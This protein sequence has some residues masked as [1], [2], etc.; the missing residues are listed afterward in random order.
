MIEQEIQMRKAMVLNLLRMIPEN[1]CN[2]VVEDESLKS[3]PGL[4]APSTRE[5][6]LIPAAEPAVFRL[7]EVQLFVI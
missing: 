3:N 5:S 1:K 6:E 7:Q 4:S 2:L